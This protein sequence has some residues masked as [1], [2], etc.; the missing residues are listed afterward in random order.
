MSGCGSFVT[1]APAAAS[2]W[3]AGTFQLVWLAPAVATVLFWMYR[4]A[5]PG[6]MALG[7]LWVAFDPRKQGWHDKLAHTV[8]VRRKG[9]NTKSVRFGEP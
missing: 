6:K 5:T 1:T 9:G 2:G 4:Q 7:L 8:V 3:S